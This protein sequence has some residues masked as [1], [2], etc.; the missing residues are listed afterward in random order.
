MR[1]SIL[2]RA[3][4][5]VVMSIGVIAGVTAE[6]RAETNA[7]PAVLGTGS[8]GTVRPVGR[9]YRANYR[10]Y[11]RPYARPYASA[12]YYQPYGYYS[13]AAPAWGTYSRPYHDGYR[14]SANYRVPLGYYPPAIGYYGPWYPRYYYG[15]GYTPF[16]S[17][18]GQ[19]YW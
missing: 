3:A 13:Y 11:A 17:P 16:Y 15:A 7:R 18:W 4:Q 19:Y 8:E 1:S 9:G 2:F 10:A 14:Y 6:T 5:V 12:G